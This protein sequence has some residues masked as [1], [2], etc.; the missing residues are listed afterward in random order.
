M[1]KT[2]LVCGFGTGI[3]RSVAERFGKEGF[4]VGLVARSVERLDAGVKALEAK[5]VKAASFPTDLADVKAIPELAARVRAA[6]GGLTVIHWNAYAGG[7]KDLLSADATALRAIFDVPVAS[8]VTLVGAALPDLRK[9][10][11][12]AVLITNGGFAKMDPQMEA[13]TVAIDANVGAMALSLA[14][15]AKDKLSGLLHAKLKPENVYVVQ[16]MVN[17][18]VK[19]TR[20]DSGNATLEPNAIADRFWSLYKARTEI[21]AEIS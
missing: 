20:F 7:A 16:L 18:M 21:R 9:A 3:S 5:G 6:L 13:M 19:G 1:A 8:L 11:G 17:G 10:D 4:S 2:I 14:N 15:A 12:A